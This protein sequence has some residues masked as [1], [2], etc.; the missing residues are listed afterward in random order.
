MR[1]IEMDL[2]MIDGVARMGGRNGGW[3]VGFGFGLDDGRNLRICGGGGLV[4][5]QRS[6]G[7]ARESTKRSLVSKL[8]PRQSAIKQYYNNQHK[9]Q[10]LFVCK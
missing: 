1:A 9:H 8:Q 7:F 2:I 6:P 10:L 5:H 3:K 4:E